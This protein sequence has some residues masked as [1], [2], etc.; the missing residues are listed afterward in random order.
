MS[1]ADRGENAVCVSVVIPVYNEREC[2]P[3]LLAELEA[4]LATIGEVT[5][6]L[7]VNDGSTDG[8]ASML[9][10]AEA[11]NPALRVLHLPQNRGQSA[12]FSRGFAEARGRVI[13]TLDADGQNPPEEIPRL[14]EALRDGVDVV[15]GY[16]ATRRDTRWKRV[17]SRIANRI[18]NRISGETIRD[19]GCSL[20]A[21][22]ADYLKR[23]PAEF[24][25]MHRFL[26][27]LCRM[28]GARNVVELPVAHR[29]RQGGAS[30]YGTWNRAARSFV[31][32]LA[33]RWMQR[34]WVG[35]KV[36]GEAEVNLDA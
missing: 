20:K 17:Q 31:D 29:E 19:T 26:P 2:L 5:E 9:D 33:V 36:N 34:R 7:L 35:G 1:R 28:V 4:A 23:I 3:G 11:E 14:V 27:T 30:K 21:F 16:R 25:G 10:Q 18:R 8:S 22:R 12:A 24:D 6:V 15:A 32:L 13:V